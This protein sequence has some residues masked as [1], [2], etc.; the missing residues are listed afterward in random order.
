MKKRDNALQFSTSSASG[1]DENEIKDSRFWGW[2]DDLQEI[3]QD[4]Q[5]LDAICRVPFI[6]Q[7]LGN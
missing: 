3:K 5:P 1:D 7:K 2:T 6:T 4:Y